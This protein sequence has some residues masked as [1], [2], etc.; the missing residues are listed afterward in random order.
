MAMSMEVVD[1]KSSEDQGSCE[2]ETENIPPLSEVSA[3]SIVL[4]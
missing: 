2:V 1:V 3:L 4:F